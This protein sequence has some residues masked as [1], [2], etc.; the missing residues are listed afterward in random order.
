MCLLPISS[1]LEVVENLDDSDLLQKSNYLW[2]ITPWVEA[3]GLHAHIPLLLPRYYYNI[4]EN[5]EGPA[6]DHYRIHRHCLCQARSDFLRLN[7]YTR[8]VP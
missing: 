6:V 4:D 5:E 8:I 2:H 7:M 1:V 3:I